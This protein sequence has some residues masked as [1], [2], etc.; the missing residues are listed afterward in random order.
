MS[1]LWLGD[2]YVRV[3]DTLTLTGGYTGPATV[4]AIRPIRDIAEGALL[5][6]PR[7]LQLVAVRRRRPARRP[8]LHRLSRQHPAG[9]LHARRAVPGRRTGPG[10][11]AGRRRAPHTLTVL[12]AATVRATPSTGGVPDAAACSMWSRPQ[13]AWLPVPQRKGDDRMTTV[14]AGA[15]YARAAITLTWT[16]TE[17]YRRELPLDQVAHAARRSV[18][19]LAADP[20]LLHGRVGDRLAD[21]LTGHQDEDTVVDEPEVEITTTDLAD[22]PTLAELVDQARRVL[23]GESDTGR[24]TCAGR[25]LAALLAGLRR[26]QRIDQ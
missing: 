18:P 4:I 8:V 23:Q 22:Q 1:R 24:T 3:G 15:A 13:R 20:S 25:A 6:D 16:F 9:L 26:E 19:E 5:I 7:T 10:S 11:P 2:G 14:E 21:L 12:P 17:T